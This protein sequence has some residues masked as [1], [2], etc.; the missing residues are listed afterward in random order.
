MFRSAASKVVWVGRATV[1]FVGLAVILAVV[2]GM[3]SAAFG[4]NGGNFILGSL[5]NTA[6]AITKLTGNVSGGPSLQ[7][8]NNKTDAGSRGLQ[9]NVAE[10]KPPILVNATAGKATN[11]NVD[12]L[13]GQNST[14]FQQANAA[15]GGDLSGN[16]PNPEIKSGA[17]GPNEV[18][19]G[20]LGS[21]DTFKLSS[22]LNV[23]PPSIPANNCAESSISISG[24]ADGSLQINQSM[25]FPSRNFDDNGPVAL[26]NVRTNV[27][28]TVFYTLCNLSATAVDPPSG[29]WVYLVVRLSGE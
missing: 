26:T 4:A 14:D 19:D 21:A 29:Q 23:D 6:T 2:F 16:Y 9:V 22:T 25:L 24:V 10:N 3:A 7:V 8:V 27:S 20:S 15:A 11:L 1:F 28:D 5:N 17:V 18:A 13:D 12:K